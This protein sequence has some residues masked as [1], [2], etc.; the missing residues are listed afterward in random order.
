MQKLYFKNELNIKFK[1]YEKLTFVYVVSLDCFI[2][3]LLLPPLGDEDTSVL[4]DVS[5]LVMVLDWLEG[6]TTPGVVDCSTHKSIFSLSS[7]E[8]AFAGKG[9]GGEDIVVNDGDE[10]SLY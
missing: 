9:G 5:S 8:A 7:E 1:K 2:G 6:N 10:A 3:G 4:I